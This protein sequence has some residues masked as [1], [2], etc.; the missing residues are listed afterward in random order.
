MATRQKK[1]D[2][3]K[4]AFLTTIFPKNKKFLPVFF[5]SLENQSFKNFDVIV[6]N[7][8]LKNFQN[9]KK[10]FK[11][12][13]I[14]DINKPSTPIKN[15]E[16]GINY[17]IKNEYDILIFGDS[18]DF[19]KKNRVEISLELLKKNDIV[20]NDLTL[21]NEKNII[22]EMY[23]SKR[24]NNYKKIDLA[25]IVNKNIFGLSNTAIKLKNLKKFNLPNYLIAAD[26]Y[27]FSK[28]LAEGKKAIFTNKTITFYRQHKNNIA[29]MKKMSNEFLKKSLIVKKKHYKALS[30]ISN[31]FKKKLDKFKNQD[32]NKKK[33]NY[34]LWWEQA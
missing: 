27:I 24:I 31:N 10:N 16:I 1:L 30:K 9:F 2:K 4:I 15:R 19:F 3:T 33:I 21:F 25:F 8:G 34:P 32:N 11:K 28:L 17:C 18:D 20:V 26:W 12:L 6:V 22:Q 7:D 5:N 23:L 13:K 14:I 29:G